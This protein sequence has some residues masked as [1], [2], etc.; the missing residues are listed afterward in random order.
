MK[1]SASTVFLATMAIGHGAALPVAADHGAAIEARDFEPCPSND[2]N[3]GPEHVRRYQ[4]QKGGGGDPGG[5]HGPKAAAVEI[6]GEFSP[7]DPEDPS[8]ASPGKVRRYQPE[9]GGGGD[10]GGDHGPKAAAVEIRGEFSP[11]D[12]GD[13]SCPNPGKVRR[14]QPEK[15]GGGDPGDGPDHVR[16]YQPEKGGGGDPGECDHGDPSCGG[17]SKVRRYQP[18]KGGGGDPGDDH[19][20]HGIGV[21]TAGTNFAPVSIVYNPN[22]PTDPRCGG[23]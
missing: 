3:C 16:R 2:P 7:C 13:P 5:D 9:K 17:D 6:R 15:G 11:C 12:P 1:F 21:A 18:E 23:T 22:D 19:G 8:C 10:P 14:Y 4:P 20:L